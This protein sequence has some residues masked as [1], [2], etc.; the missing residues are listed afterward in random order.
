[1]DTRK[2]TNVSDSKRKLTN[3]SGIID[4]KKRLALLQPI[5]DAN[6][7]NEEELNECEKL[8]MKN[9]YSEAVIK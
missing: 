1:M 3:L 8:F 4:S 7:V 5:Q 9:E 2:H 6:K